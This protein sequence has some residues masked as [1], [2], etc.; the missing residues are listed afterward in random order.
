MF[1]TEF[2]PRTL[3]VLPVLQVTTVECENPEC[4][5]VHGIG[6][7]IGW[8]FWDVMIGVEF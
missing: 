6:L 3:A 5:E 1:E 8:L 4:G 7:V 2:H